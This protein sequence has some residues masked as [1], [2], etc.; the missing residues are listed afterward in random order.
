MTIRYQLRTVDGEDAGT[1]A[2]LLS[3]WKPG[4]EF[5]GHGNQP[6]RIVA[7]DEHAKV[8]HVEPV[9]DGQLRRTV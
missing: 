9:G 5:I 7:I 6:Y 8:W 4:L 1:F 2:T 3:D